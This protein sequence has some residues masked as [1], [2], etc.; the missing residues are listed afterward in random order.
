MALTPLLLGRV[1]DDVVRDGA[2]GAAGGL[3]DDGRVGLNARDGWLRWPWADWPRWWLRTDLALVGMGM[4]MLTLVLA[5]QS[6]VDRSRLGVAT[7]LGQFTRS[8]G[9]AVGVVVMGAIAAASVPGARGAAHR[10]GAR[11]ASCV[12][13][14]PGGLGRCADRGDQDPRRASNSGIGSR[15][16]GIGMGAPSPSSL[17]RWGR[18][19]RGLGLRP[20]RPNSHEALFQCVRR[21]GSETHSET[22]LP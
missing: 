18:G 11:A 19:I 14:R 15:E 5:M 2:T 8:I 7:S 6:A 9:G 4:T 21:F 22:P 13:Q 20:T 1:G 3:S 12:R 16:L 17:F 10:D